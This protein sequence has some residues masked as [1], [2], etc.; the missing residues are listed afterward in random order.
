[1]IKFFTALFGFIT[2]LINEIKLYII[3]KEKR[4]IKE[5][6]NEAINSKDAKYFINILNGRLRN[7]SSDK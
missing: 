5:R 2:V 1:M 3:K 6:I 4:N 7:G